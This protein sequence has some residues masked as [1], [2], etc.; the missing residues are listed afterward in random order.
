MLE[1]LAET[2]LVGL[3]VGYLVWTFVVNVDTIPKWLRK[4][5]DAVY[6]STGYTKPFRCPTCMSFWLSLVFWI[7]IMMNGI[8]VLQWPLIVVVISASSVISLATAMALNK[9]NTF[10]LTR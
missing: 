8:W 6:V 4:C 1:L 9:L 7:S 5:F 2:V 10:I 3:A